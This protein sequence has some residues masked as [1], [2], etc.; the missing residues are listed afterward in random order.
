MRAAVRL[1]VLALPVV[2]GLLRSH[3]CEPRDDGFICRLSSEV[4]LVG[5]K[6]KFQF[7]TEDKP[8]VC[9]KTKMKN[10]K[11][12][13]GECTGG[14]WANFVS[15]SD[16]VYGTVRNGEHIFHISPS[17]DGDGSVVECMPASMVDDMPEQPINKDE[18]PEPVHSNVTFAMAK[19]ERTGTRRRRLYQDDGK[20]LDIL[21]V[22]TKE[23][24]CRYAGKGWPCT[25]DSSTTK[26]MRGLIDLAI[27]ETNAAYELSGVDTQLRL[28]YAYQHPTYEESRDGG[29]IRHLSN[30]NDGEMDD[31]HD[32]R[33]LYGADL[34]SMVANVPR[35]CGVAYTG[36]HRANLLYS[37]LRYSCLKG[38]FVMAHELG[39]NVRWLRSG[40]E[41]RGL[42]PGFPPLLRQLG[43]KHDRGTQNQCNAKEYNYG[44]RDPDAEFRT[45][46]AYG[47][48]KDQCDNMP[49]NG[50]PQIQRFSSSSGR[51]N[52][53]KVGND[54]T[55]AVRALNENVKEAASYFPAMDCQRNADCDDDDRSTNDTCNRSTGVCVFTKK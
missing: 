12:W 20:H 28:V 47:C 35:F 1:L 8:I 27:E 44:Y 25:V 36:P 38:G 53:K 22:W 4:K 50:C 31:V 43:V 6:M 51:Y 34:V 13:H 54:E 30:G 16:G 19:V 2:S 23:A 21:V 48:R 3:D 15:E 49:K 10:R 17:V 52:G 29:H 24:E 9:T 37:V 11:L 40:T 26:G 39:H 55:N 33:A 7:E 41:R 14:A 18:A 46:M 5:K 45:I 32:L 42:S